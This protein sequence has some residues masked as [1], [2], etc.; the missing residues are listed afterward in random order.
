PRLQG[1][2]ALLAFVPVNIQ[3]VE[4]RPS[5]EPN[6]GVGCATPPGPNLIR[7][8]GRILQA[9]CRGWDLASGPEW[10]ALPPA[11]R[12]RQSGITQRPK[13][14]SRRRRCRGAVLSGAFDQPG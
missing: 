9:M 3:N 4:V 13:S 8:R 11:L 14:R 5:W 10:E 2:E 7:V 12:V 1:D 6:V